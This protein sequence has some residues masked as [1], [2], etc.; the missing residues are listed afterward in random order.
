MSDAVI[1]MERS[2]ARGLQALAWCLHRDVS[3]QNFGAELA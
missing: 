2:A 3:G 1:S